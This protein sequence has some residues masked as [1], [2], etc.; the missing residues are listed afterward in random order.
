MIYFIFSE[1]K[2]KFLTPSLTGTPLIFQFLTERKNN[3]K[4]KITN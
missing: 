3:Y 2:Q 4:K 1:L